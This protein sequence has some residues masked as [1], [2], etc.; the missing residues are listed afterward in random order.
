MSNI[1]KMMHRNPQRPHGL[2]Y[3]DVVNIFQNKYLFLWKILHGM[4]LSFESRLEHFHLYIV[5]QNPIKMVWCIDSLKESFRFGQNL[6]ESRRLKAAD[7]HVWEDDDAG[8]EFALQHVLPVCNVR[9]HVCIWD[10]FTVVKKAN[11]S[12]TAHSQSVDCA[13]LQDEKASL[14]RLNLICHTDWADTCVRFGHAGKISNLIINEDKV[15]RSISSP[16]CWAEELAAFRPPQI[17]TWTRPRCKNTNPE[18][19]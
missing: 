13:W 14:C 12:Q 2:I 8:S 18:F 3:L 9:T 6:P 11:R 1:L 19:R 5:T 16:V 7:P 17:Y 4:R 15:L 10:V